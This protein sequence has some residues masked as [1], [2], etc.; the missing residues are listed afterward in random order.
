MCNDYY[1]GRFKK[2]GK[3]GLEVKIKN[4]VKGF[5]DRDSLSKIEEYV[6]ETS[7]SLY[8][9]F[10]KDFFDITEDNRRLFL[11]LMLG[12]S[13]RTISVIFGQEI[14][15]VYNKKSRLKARIA[16]SDTANKEQYLKFF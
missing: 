6:N 2:N 11:Y 1:Q 7:D 12:F 13:S 4:I 15:A 9:T 3:D 16:K 14:S 8:S 10:K 5:T